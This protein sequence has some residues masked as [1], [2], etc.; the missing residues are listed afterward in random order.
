MFCFDHRKVFPKELNSCEDKLKSC[1]N[2]NAFRKTIDDVESSS[3][4][5]LLSKG[6]LLEVAKAWQ[7]SYAGH[8]RSTSQG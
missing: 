6:T 7:S 5:L 8:S 2:V 1:D 3:Q 4:I